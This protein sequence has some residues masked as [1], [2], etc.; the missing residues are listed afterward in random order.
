M[1]EKYIELLNVRIEENRKIENRMLLVMIF[2][3]IAFP[4]LREAK[5]TEIS[6]GPFKI[7]D[8]QI[9]WA[10]VPTVYSYCHYKYVVVYGELSSQITIYNNLTQ[11]IFKFDKL[12]NYYNSL[13]LPFSFMDRISKNHSKYKSK[14]EAIIFGVLI[15]LPSLLVLLFIQF[16]F[17][18]YSVF[19]LIK[20]LNFISIIDYVFIVSP[21]ILFISMIM[22]IIKNLKKNKLLQNDQAN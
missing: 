13:L 9:I 21:I 3:I 2:S 22:Y 20:K 17:V 4:L 10:S 1:E 15:H 18:F 14:L 5:I 8:L 6:L 16:F 12:E 7:N 19:I 11:K